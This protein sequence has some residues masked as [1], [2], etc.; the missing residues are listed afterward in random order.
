MKNDTYEEVERLV[1]QMVP[2]IWLPREGSL[3]ES[4]Y[5]KLETLG[6]KMELPTLRNV[7]RTR[8]I[9]GDELTTVAWP[10]LTQQF[11]I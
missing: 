4:I 8:Q 3:H 10:Y 6:L 7:A 11:K 9:A 5:E 1:S 2:L